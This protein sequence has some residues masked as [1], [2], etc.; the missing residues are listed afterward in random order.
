LLSQLVVALVYNLAS[1]VERAEGRFFRFGDV[2]AD[3]ILVEPH[4]IIQRE[5]F[6]K[7]PGLLHSNVDDVLNEDGGSQDFSALFNSP[8][9]QHMRWQKKP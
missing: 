7:S 3:K 2:A 9:K 5:E 1:G 4:F 8:V 6:R